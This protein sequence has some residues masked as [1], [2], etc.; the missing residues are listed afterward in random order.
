[1]APEDQL[2]RRMA[3]SIFCR[4]R[5]TKSR[6]VSIMTYGAA[7]KTL[8]TSRQRDLLISDIRKFR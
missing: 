8:K 1:M 7:L 3:L 6:S 2:R 4:S 5:M